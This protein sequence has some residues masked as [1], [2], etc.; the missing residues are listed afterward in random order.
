MPISG[1]DRYVCSI[2]R[3]LPYFVRMAGIFA[4]VPIAVAFLHETF[5]ADIAPEGCVR[6]VTHNVIPHIAESVCSLVALSA[7][8]SLV[9]S[10]S[11]WV[12]KHALVVLRF[13]VGFQVLL[14]HLIHVLI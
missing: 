6:Y 9:L 13:D 14:M 11:V 1:A 3:V 4:L 5:S 12:D 2:Q 7:D 8:Q 10:A